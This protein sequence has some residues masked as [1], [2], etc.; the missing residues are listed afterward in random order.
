MHNHTD[1]PLDD[2]GLLLVRPDLRVGTEADT[3]SDVWA[4]G[5][6]AAVPDLAVGRSG[7]YTVPNAQ[8]A[9]RQGKRLAKNI[10]ATLRGKPT[11][12]YV[13]HSSEW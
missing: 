7:A 1:L 6:D 3:V 9:V 5:D 8:L 2:R 10:L 11:T 13:H 4:A 12:N